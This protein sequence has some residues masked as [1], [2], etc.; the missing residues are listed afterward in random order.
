MWCKSQGELAKVLIHRRRATGVRSDLDLRFVSF[1]C[2]V[3]LARSLPLSGSSAMKQWDFTPKFWYSCNCICFVIFLFVCLFA[4]LVGWFGFMKQ[5]FA[6]EPRSALNSSYSYFNILSTGF[7]G[8]CHYASQTVSF[9]Y[10]RVW[11]QSFMLARYL[12][13][14]LSHSSSPKLIFDQ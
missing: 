12:L 14:H 7:I 9:V 4:C 1:K 10:I 2:C 5:V 8:M 11:T 3:I 13:Y 6:V